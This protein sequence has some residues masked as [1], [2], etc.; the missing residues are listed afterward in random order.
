M[1]WIY[2][3]AFLNGLACFQGF[4]PHYLMEKDV[5]VVTLN[6]R[7]GAFGKQ[8]KMVLSRILLSD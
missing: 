1:V 3:G 2:G 4:G 8:I 6:Y 7:I 5:I